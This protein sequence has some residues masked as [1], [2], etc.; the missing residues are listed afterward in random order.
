MHPATKEISTTR[1]RRL[2]PALALV[3]ALAGASLSMDPGP[4]VDWQPVPASGVITAPGKY[5]LAED[6]IVA[7]SPGIDVQADDVML[8]LGAHALRL[9]GVPTPGTFGVVANGRAGVRVCNGA[10]G[11][12]WYGIHASDCTGLRV[13]GVRFDDIPYIAINAAAAH[14]MAITDN[15]F[16]G[17]R[18][19]LVRDADAHYVIAIN[20]GAEDALVAKNQFD[21]EVVVGNGGTVDVETVFVLL[22]ADATRRCVVAHNT[23]RASEALGRGYA[24]WIAS[25]AQAVVTPNSIENMQYGVCLARAA[26]AV[27]CYNRFSMGK[28]RGSE[29]GQTCGVS[30]AGATDLREFANAFTGFSTPVN[31]SVGPDTGRGSARCRSHGPAAWH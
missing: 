16:T 19:D 2:Q 17:F 10:V 4:V 14:D 9:A 1:H 7:S 13:Q 25:G 6:R 21:A 22:S 15:A 12:F 23:M 31:A 8:D 18:Y 24:V 29:I 11:G 20:T 5:R 28:A 3:L 27:V 26:S 30:A